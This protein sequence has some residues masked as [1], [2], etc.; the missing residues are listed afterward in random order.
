MTQHLEHPNC[1]PSHWP[2]R[3]KQGTEKDNRQLSHLKN[4]NR[5]TASANAFQ[6]RLHGVHTS[7]NPYDNLT[8]KF[9]I[10]ETKTRGTKGL[11]GMTKVT[12]QINEQE[13]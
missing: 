5:K 13:V 12:E 3:G 10:K 7:F 9:Q 6:A 4:H 11:G 2:S 1:S 8:G